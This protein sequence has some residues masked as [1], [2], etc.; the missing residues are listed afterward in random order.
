MRKARTA[1]AF[2]SAAIAGVTA[3]FL[4]PLVLLALG[5]L[6]PNALPPPTGFELRVDAGLANYRRAAELLPLGLMALNSVWVALVAVPVSL[7]VASWAG[8]AAARLPRRDAVAVLAFAVLAF[9]VPATSLAVGRAVVYRAVGAFGGPWPLLA[10]SLI[11]TTPVAVLL[12]AWRYRTLPAHLWDLAA[13]LGLSPWSTW[14]RV[15]LP[16]TWPVTG[17]IGAVVFALTWGNVLDPLFFVADPRWATLPIGIRSLASLPPTSQP[18]MLA[19]A[20][21]A[22]IPALVVAGTLVR[23]G[24]RS[25]EVP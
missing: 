22:T 16:M 8:F 11:G 2:R 15:V 1:S 19:G 7:V 24:V 25:L 9:A 14:R 5:S 20:A 21:L 23:R 18:V 12:F 3:V 17:A 6:R 10:P 4:A 13:E